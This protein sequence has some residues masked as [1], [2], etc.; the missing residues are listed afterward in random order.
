MATS[1]PNWAEIVTAVSTAV[2]AIGLLSAVFA[3]LFAARQV[4]ESEKSRQ[5]AMAADFLRRW[6]EADLVET[7]HLIGQFE[8][9]QQL[10]AE[11][12]KYIEAN[13]MQAFVLYRELDYFEQLAA[14]EEVGAF[15][16]ELIKLLLG[17]RLVTRWEMWKPSIDA[18]GSDPMG[19]RVYPMFEA[20]VVRMRAALGMP[21]GASTP[22]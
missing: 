3:A 15:D 7:R 22:A 2:G 20:L 8:T 4:R 12:R 17:H 5:S 16:F 1:D 19:R 21:E 14:L 13:S 18:M 10:S 11:F 9:P 6:D